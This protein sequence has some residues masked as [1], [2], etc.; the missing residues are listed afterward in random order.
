M[1]TRFG[2]GQACS[3][4]LESQRVHGRV[5]RLRRRQRA[6]VTDDNRRFLLPVDRLHAPPRDVLVL[7]SRLDGALT[8][9]R[10]QGAFLQHLFRVQRYAGQIL[11][12]RVH[13]K[14]DFAAFLKAA[15]RRGRVRYIHYAGHG[16]YKPAARRVELVL[17]YEVINLAD[18]ADRSLFAGLAYKVLIFSCCEIGQ[19]SRV[20]Q[21]LADE[22]K[23]TVICYRQ[24]VSDAYANTAEMLMYDLFQTTGRSPSDVVQSVSRALLRMGIHVRSAGELLSRSHVLRCY[25]PKSNGNGL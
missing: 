20:M 3:F 15:S 10:E 8:S 21:Q 23:A 14:P 16:E 11:Y 1:S 22:S 19:A 5:T 18:P 6:I 4:W 7:E 2:V 13:S 24:P 9:P 12:E 25:V 17:T